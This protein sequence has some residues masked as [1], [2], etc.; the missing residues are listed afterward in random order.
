MCILMAL[1]WCD[2]ALARAN[3]VISGPAAPP[4]VPPPAKPDPA[5]AKA[6]ADPL[7]KPKVNVKIKRKEEKG[8]K[9]KEE[10]PAKKSKK[11]GGGAA[12]PLGLLSSYGSDEED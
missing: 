2:A 3:Q 10:Q 4:T 8:G 12:N 1:W 11:E 9:K 5:K 6:A 7:V